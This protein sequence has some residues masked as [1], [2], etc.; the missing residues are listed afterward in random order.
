MIASVDFHESRWNTLPHKF[1]AGT[2]DISGPIAL[3]VAMDYLDAIGRQRIFEH[4]QALALSA[5]ERLAEIPGIRIFGPKH[6]RGG[7]VSFVLPGV[8][9]HDVITLA[10][11]H[12]IALRGGH[13]CNQPLMRKLGVPSTARASFYFYNTFEEID[14]LAEVV[15]EIQKF[16]GG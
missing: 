13:H 16:F 9:A 6:G 5:I 8:H 15:K 1:E 2:P 4:D 10:D 14:R 3:H 12:G 11:H 7:L